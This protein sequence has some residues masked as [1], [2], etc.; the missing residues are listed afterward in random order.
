MD[1]LISHMCNNSIPEACEV[2][3]RNLLRKTAA[4]LMTKP[5]GNARKLRYIAFV[6]LGRH[7]YRMLKHIVK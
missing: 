4:Q 6:L 2:W 7:G 1:K 3:S 5:I